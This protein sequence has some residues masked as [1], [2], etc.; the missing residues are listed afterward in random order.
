MSRWDKGLLATTLYYPYEIRDDKPYF[1]D[2]PDLKLPDEVK[3][4]AGHIVETKAG[5][6]EPS[7]VT[8]S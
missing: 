6:F 2:I 3:Q 1:E 4:L 7:A 5:H 8:Q